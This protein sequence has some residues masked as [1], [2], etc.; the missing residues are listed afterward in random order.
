[1][2]IF[3]G[4]LEERPS[5][6]V[7]AM[8]AITPTTQAIGQHLATAP[9]REREMVRT[10]WEAYQQMTPEAREALQ[11]APRWNDM[12]DLAERRLPEAVGFDLEG[13][14]TLS[15][16]REALAAD[17]TFNIDRTL[18]ALTGFFSVQA[19][20]DLAEEW[21]RQQQELLRD[22]QRFTPSLFIQGSDGIVRPVPDLLTVA[23][24]RK[25]LAE[26]TLAETQ[27]D[28]MP[29]LLEVE[30]DERRARIEESKARVKDILSTVRERNLLLPL[31]VDQL[32]VAVNLA[33]QEFDYLS[34]A[35]PI[36]VQQLEKQVERM[37][38]D[39]S[40]DEQLLPHQIDKLSQENALLAAQTDLAVHELREAEELMEIRGREYQERVALLRAQA[41]QL[42]AQTSR[43]EQMT[44]EEIAQLR[45]ET[46]R[47]QEETRDLI[48]SR[49]WRRGLAEV[50][51]DDL[52]SQILSRVNR[53]SLDQRVE[54][55]LER[56]F[57]FQLD[58]DQWEREM[59][60]LMND[61]QI[62]MDE[63]MAVLQEFAT[64]S[65][66]E[67]GWAEHA[68]Q[69]IL[70][71]HNIDMGLR[72]QTY[73][74]MLIKAQITDMELTRDLQRLV[75]T[76]Q[77]EQTEKE[78]F[79]QELAINIDKDLR[80]WGLQ[81][82]SDRIELQR[83]AT[84]QELDITRDMNEHRKRVDFLNWM[85]EQGRLELGWENLRESARQFEQTHNLRLEEFDLEKEVFNLQK[86]R[87]LHD[88]WIQEAL[89]ESELETA[90][91]RRQ[92]ASIE[93][94]SRAVLAAAGLFDRLVSQDPVT[95]E[96]FAFVED[97]Q[98]GQRLRVPLTEG[99]TTALMMTLIEG[100]TGPDYFNTGVFMQAIGSAN[101]DTR[102]IPDTSERAL[103]TN[104]NLRDALAA[105]GG[106]AAAAGAN[107]LLQASRLTGTLGTAAPLPPHVKAILLGITGLLSAI[108]IRNAMEVADSQGMGQ[109]GTFLEVLES[110]APYQIKDFADIPEGGGDLSL[111]IRLLSPEEQTRTLGS[112]STSLED[113]A[114]WL[115]GIGLRFDAWLKARLGL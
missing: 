30:I 62:S 70:T 56:M 58:R 98:T 91:Q 88:M 34:Q 86:D 97:P 78:L 74:E 89:A 75:Q 49:E 19:D 48:E 64:R 14:R 16:T 104:P 110:M 6:F 37:S 39:L 102:T 5:P 83:W 22:R 84:Q 69:R 63:R 105:G 46:E 109:G 114:N 101:I 108:G 42:T 96:Y 68:R 31:R 93:I 66:V 45:A 53:D 95:G 40:R 77:L 21:I 20:E 24:Q 100:L 36:L 1:M 7:Q 12:L 79:L 4:S 106:V 99:E 92:H 67:L 72:A 52:R 115:E 94:T 71:D 38:F 60:E 28:V 61:H 51:I 90:E 81:N 47:L 26:A 11:R 8:R 107:W 82:E 57:Q 10:F 18:D 43:I 73:S 112:H 13:R 55:R 111:D 35:N 65:D 85:V 59:T 33:S 17:E 29:E 23:Q 15:L 87:T 103:E 2:G 25:G 76:T 80:E 9:D 41:L 113:I 54:D 3:L 50:Q 27:A 32:Q 44:P